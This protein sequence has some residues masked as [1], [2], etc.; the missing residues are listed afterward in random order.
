VQH[1]GGIDGFISLL[2]FM[3]REGIGMIVLT[4]LSGNNPVPTIVVRGVYDR[5][6][7]LEPVDWA[8]RVREQQAESRESDDAAEEDER[9]EGT[10]PS[11]PLADYAGSYEHPGYGV[12]TVEVDGGEL[13]ATFNKMSAPL[14]HFHYDVFE[15]AE[16]PLVAFGE[17]KVM[18]RYNKKGEIDRLLVPFEPNVD[19]IV[20]RR[21]AE[22][23]QK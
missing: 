3:P 15:V 5:V 8:A 23:T 19:D 7:G 17:L 22:A 16:D 10:A 12:I 11:H 4:N 9:R 2:S 21:V 14:V 18:F 1:G 6:L 13:K 20:F